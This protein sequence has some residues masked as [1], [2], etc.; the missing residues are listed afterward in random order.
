MTWNCPKND[1]PCWQNCRGFECRDRDDDLVTL[2]GGPPGDPNGERMA[3]K[4]NEE[5]PS[6]AAH[7]HKVATEALAE[8]ARLQLLEKVDD[9]VKAD[10]ARFRWLQEHTVATGLERFVGQYKTQFLAQAVDAAIKAEHARED[11]M[12]V[13]RGRKV[14]DLTRQIRKQQGRS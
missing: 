4:L 3:L 6:N 12:S 9:W 11:L 5:A 14:G 10:A 1:K 13:D 7:W 8:V 2:G